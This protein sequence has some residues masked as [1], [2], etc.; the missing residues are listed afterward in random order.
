MIPG[1]MGLVLR[2][3]MA[4]VH[5]SWQGQ[6]GR[7]LPA[8]H[9]DKF[10]GR[11]MPKPRRSSCREQPHSAGGGTHRS[12]SRATVTWLQ[13]QVLHSQGC[14]FCCKED[15]RAQQPEESAKVQTGSFKRMRG[16]TA[17]VTRSTPGGCQCLPLS[18]LCWVCTPD[19][20]LP[21]CLSLVMATAIIQ[22]PAWST[23]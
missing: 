12:H 16:A 22:W 7:C 6:S 15:T 14:A 10:G 2:G 8:Q 3:L 5:L 23:L 9:G 1:A 11:G 20:S 21:H 13:S 4:S 17:E 19:C 18:P